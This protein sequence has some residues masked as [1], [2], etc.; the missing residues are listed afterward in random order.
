ML[1]GINAVISVWPQECFVFILDAYR[2]LQMSKGPT[3]HGTGR[4]HGVSLTGDNSGDS[5]RTRVVTTRQD[6]YNNL[7][8]HP[9]PR[10]DRA[11]HDEDNGQGSRYFAQNPLALGS[12]SRKALHLKALGPLC[13]ALFLG[14][15]C[16]TLHRR[17]CGSE[18]DRVAQDQLHPSRLIALSLTYH[19][20]LQRANAHATLSP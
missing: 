18:R 15:A 5:G 8:H 12:S 20:K 7:C 2:E 11:S 3:F 10:E 17:L 4:T 16:T 1:R 6:R 19:S 13:G 9:P 14:H